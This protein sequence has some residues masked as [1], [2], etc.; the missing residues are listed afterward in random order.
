MLVKIV[1]A[2]RYDLGPVDGDKCIAVLA[3]LFVP[4]PYSMAGFVNRATGRTAC[5]KSDELLAALAAYPGTAA[6][7]RSESY[8]VGVL[9]GIRGCPKD[10]TNPCIC[11]PMSNCVGNS[12]L[13]GKAAVNRVRDETVRPSELSPANHNTMGDFSPQFLTA[14]LRF[15]CHLL[16]A[17]KHD[18]TFENRQ[19]LH[20]SVLHFFRVKIHT[21]DKR[22]LHDIG[23][24]VLSEVPTTAFLYSLFNHNSLLLQLYIG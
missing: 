12:G 21:I 14:G 18:V 22:C 16:D 13:I 1:L 6:A 3:A 20:L 23:I 10:E 8:I 7:A 17:A 9:C 5:G 19:P 11:F 15:T 24:I 2:A 4:Q